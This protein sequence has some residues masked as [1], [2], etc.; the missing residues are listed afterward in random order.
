MKIST[1]G[2]TDAYGADGPTVEIFTRFWISDM[3]LLCIWY[4][5][6]MCI[7]SWLS[8]VFCDIPLFGTWQSGISQVVWHCDSV[9]IVTK[10]YII[11]YPTCYSFIMLDNQLL[12]VIYKYIYFYLFIVTGWKFQRMGPPT[13]AARMVPPLK[14]FILDENKKKINN[15]YT[16][17][18]S[19]LSSIIKWIKVGYLY[20]ICKY[21]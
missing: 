4:S 13:P 18:K 21:F 2:T 9:I 15:L 3:K 12:C 7:K 5:L 11:K 6:F 8:Q 17:H 1:D 14:L 20:D 10:S 16:Q 19:W